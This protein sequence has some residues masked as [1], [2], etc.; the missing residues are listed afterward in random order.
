M[1]VVESRMQLQ[2]LVKV[3]LFPS[4]EGV[5]VSSSLEVVSPKNI[6][7]TPLPSRMST[8]SLKTGP[9]P[10]LVTL[11]FFSPRTFCKE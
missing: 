6:S 5:Q 11:H 7:I 3:V 2:T 9:C 1:F 8:R 4:G 10:K